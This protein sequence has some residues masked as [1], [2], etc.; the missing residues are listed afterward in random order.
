MVLEPP[1]P[2]V[3]L[4]A[5]SNDEAEVA[6]D[7]DLD[8]PIAKRKTTRSTTCKLHAKLDTYNVSHFIPYESISPQY[9]SF[10]TALESITIPSDC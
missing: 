6:R 9:R 3:Q 10:I 2:L 8:L 5:L 7:V 1:L 4:M